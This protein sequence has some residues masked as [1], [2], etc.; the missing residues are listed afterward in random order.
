MALK[1][2]SKRHFR[3]TKKIELVIDGA[4]YG[5]TK[6]VNVRATNV[7]IWNNQRRKGFVKKNQDKKDAKYW[8]LKK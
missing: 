2:T 6:E 4:Y 5:K 3:P 7:I 1:F 8:A